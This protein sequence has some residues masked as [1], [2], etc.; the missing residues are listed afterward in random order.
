MN[1]ASGFN[2][3]NLCL[4]MNFTAWVQLEVEEDIW[5]NRQLKPKF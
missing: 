3:L 4:E 1:S 2:Y 5:V